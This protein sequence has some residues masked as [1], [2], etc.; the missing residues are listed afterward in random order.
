MPPGSEQKTE[1]P[2]Q[3][4]RRRTRREGQVAQSNEVNNAFVLLAGIGALALFGGHSFRCMAA[5]AEGRLGNLAGL[6]LSLSGVESV[7]ADTVGVLVGASLPAMLL[8]GTVGLLCSLLQTGVLVVPKKLAPNLKA[9]DPIKGLKN[10]FS[11]AAAMRLLMAAIKFAAIGVIVYFVVRGR[12]SWFGGLVSM[13]PW[14]ILDVSRRLC[15]SILVRVGVAMLGV[16][17]LDYAFQRWRHE[18]E[19]LMTK[20]ELK[21]ERKR[22]EGSPEVRGRQEMMRRA[23]SQRR[24]MQAVPRADVVVTNPTHVAVALEWNEEQMGAPTVVA[25]GQDLL[26]ERIKKVARENKVPVLERKDL[27]RALYVAV[28]VGSEIPEKLYY[29]VAEVLAFVLRREGK[30]R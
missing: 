20:Q 15:F 5:C 7:A 3:R 4:K 29:A 28:E 1:K 27:A 12:S 16:A 2:T 19:L 10:I 26:A 6:D 23:M 8:V 17:L 22:Q 24:M 21:E 25:K 13:S 14:G 11:L 18:K 30:A 9:I